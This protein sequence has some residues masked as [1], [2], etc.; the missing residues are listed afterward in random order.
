MELILDVRTYDDGT[1]MLYGWDKILFVFPND[2]SAEIDR[3]KYLRNG[4]NNIRTYP[5]TKN[6]FLYLYGK[7]FD[8]YG[9]IIDWNGN[10]ILNN[11]FFGPTNRDDNNDIDIKGIEIE[12]PSFL[13]ALGVPEGDYFYWKRFEFKNDITSFLEVVNSSIIIDKDYMISQVKIFNTIDGRQAIVYSTT[14]RNGSTSYSDAPVFYEKATAQISILTFKEDLIQTFEPVILFEINTMLGVILKVDECQ[15]SFN[16]QNNVCFIRILHANGTLYKSILFSTA[17]SVIKI[18]NLKNFGSENSNIIVSDESTLIPFLYG[19]YILV[20]SI[21]NINVGYIYDE[22]GNNIRELDIPEIYKN[23]GNIYRSGVLSINNTAWMLLDNSS[24]GWSLATFETPQELNKAQFQNPLITSLIPSLNQQ[25]NKN[26]I[27]NVKITFSI[28]VIKSTGKITIYE[29]KNDNQPIF[30][31]RQT[32][33]VMS[34][35]CELQ[36]GGNALSCQILQSTFNRPNSNYMIVVDNGFVRSF[37]I[38]EPLSGINKGF[39]KVTTNQLTEPNKIAESTTGTLQLTTFGTS[40]Y[41]NFSSSAEKDDFK[42]ALQNQLCD[43]I[44]INQ[45]RF[46]MSGK[47]LP[48]TR[49]KD[50]LLIEFKILSTQDKYEPNVESIINDLNTIIK[51][52]EIVLPL[53]LSNLIDQEYGFVQACKF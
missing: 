31:I 53:N 34:D 32:Y 46:R 45:S 49:K 44:P 7:D 33:P 25:I 1:Y 23:S 39:W 40:Y 19:G 51:N 48:D 3:E 10:I 42:N 13:I 17:G 43:S 50:Q 24:I 11:I 9:D 52:K 37:S 29:L 8:Q 15:A 30:N 6:Y 28:K 2:S 21:N 5:L 38:E 47:L 35:L 12:K 4:Y 16:A 27:L 18:E 41:N 26:E 20:N 14:L 22:N 36:D